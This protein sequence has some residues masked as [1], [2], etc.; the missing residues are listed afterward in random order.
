MLKPYHASWQAAQS[1]SLFLFISTFNSSWKW[2]QTQKEAR[3]RLPILQ[4]S[5]FFN[6]QDSVCLNFLHIIQNIYFEKQTIIIIKYISVFCEATSCEADGG[7]GL[8]KG[9]PPSHTQP[10]STSLSHADSCQES[11][12]EAWVREAGLGIRIKERRTG[13]PKQLW[14]PTTPSL[15]TGSHS[16]TSIMQ[17]V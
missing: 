2:K 10:P 6:L 5:L 14:S 8:Q 16:H 17:E 3:S 13:K 11:Q 1:K 7:L 9:T 15:L 4:E 12:A